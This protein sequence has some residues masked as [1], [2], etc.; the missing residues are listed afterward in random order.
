MFDSS[1]KAVGRSATDPLSL[2]GVRVLARI[3]LEKS[4]IRGV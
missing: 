3:D 1:G 4:K 2:S